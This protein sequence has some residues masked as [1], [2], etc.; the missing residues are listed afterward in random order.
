MTAKKQLT[1]AESVAARR[2]AIRYV[3]SN[4]ASPGYLCTLCPVEERFE[5]YQEKRRTKAAKQHWLDHHS[6]LFAH[7]PADPEPEWASWESARLHPGGALY[8]RLPNG[9]FQYQ[10]NPSVPPAPAYSIH[11][12][13][14]F[15]H[16]DLFLVEDPT[17]PEE[18]DDWDN[19]WEDIDDREY[20]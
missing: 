1:Y 19:S 4:T 12:V 9:M 6:D 20:R 17:A 15:L 5:K 16:G 13:W 3:G 2:D 11:S 14:E 7:Y 18:D 8:E 10:G